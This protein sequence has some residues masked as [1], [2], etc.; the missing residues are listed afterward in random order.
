MSDYTAE[1]IEAA[2]TAGD[3]YEDENRDYQNTWVAIGYDD[4]DDD[5][6]LT[7]RGEAVSFKYVA[8]KSPHEGGG[9]DVWSVIQ[10]G[11]Q[12]FK[13]PGYYA[14]HYGTDWDGD[15]KEVHAISRSVTFYE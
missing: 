1:E 6:T 11:T 4:V 8:G 2:V 13:K 9:E 3:D 12:L 5:A 7:L 10:V 15:L 14:S